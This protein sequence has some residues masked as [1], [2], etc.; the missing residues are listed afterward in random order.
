MS[1]DWMD[2]YTL[3]EAAPRRGRLKPRSEG[4]QVKR[5]IGRLRPDPKQLLP[6]VPGEELTRGRKRVLSTPRPKPKPK[7]KPPVAP[8]TLTGRAA[9]DLVAEQY[10]RVEAF[11][12]DKDLRSWQGEIYVGIDTGKEGAFGFI[13][14]QKLEITTAIDI[15]VLNIDRAG[16]TKK[17]NKRT[18]TIYDEPAIWRIVQHWLRFRGRIVV[19]I[20]E[21]AA[22][23][24][25]SGVT[26][27]A[28]G[29]GL[30]M[31]PLFL[32]SHGFRCEYIN[33]SA[34][35]KAVGLSGKDKEWSRLMAQRLWPSAPLFRK[36]DE[37]RAEALLVAEYFR[38]KRTSVQ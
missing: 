19:C 37:G 12:N 33:P 17:G 3:D 20:E 24:V 7:E 35:K 27:H 31:W 34:W 32:H 1:D 36:G 38:R 15:P 10:A 9:W 4:K 5:K 11:F 28:L 14:P 23:E 22:R 6:D 26:G 30:G 25:D 21:T 16:K 13:F 18:K 8:K 29:Y 2:A